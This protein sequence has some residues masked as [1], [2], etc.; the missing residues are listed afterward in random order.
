MLS[1]VNTP[2]N[3]NML[4]KPVAPSARKAAPTATKTPD[5]RWVRRRFT[6]SSPTFMKTEVSTGLIT[7][8]TNNDDPNTMIKVI[9]R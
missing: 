5:T 7:S 8:A 4:P 9:G 2:A 6:C 3:A 1:S